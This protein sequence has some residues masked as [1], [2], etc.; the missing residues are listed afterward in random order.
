MHSLY[1]RKRKRRPASYVEVAEQTMGAVIGKGGRRIQQ[2]STTT[3]ANVFTKRGIRDRIYIEAETD[4]A[5]K[6]A[7][8]EVLRIVVSR[9]RLLV[10]CSGCIEALSNF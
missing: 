2:I 5:I 7:K 3:G 1:S 9:S 10:A 4:G 6:R 8:Q